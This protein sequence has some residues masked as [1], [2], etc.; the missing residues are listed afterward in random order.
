MV[1]IA[2]LYYDGGLNQQQIAKRLG[3]TRQRVSRLLVSAREE[4][5]V[6]IN[7]F[8]PT[9]ADP[10]LKEQLQETFGLHDVVLAPS[11]GLE[12]SELRSQLGLV[13]AEYLATVLTAGEKVGIG[14]G[15]T[16][17]ETIQ[18]IPRTQQV[19][20]HIVPII[21][22]IGDMSPYFQ[23]NELARKLAEAFNG[24]FRHIY[25]PA[26]TRDK[27]ILK[28]LSKTQEVEQLQELWKALDVAIIG[29]GHV[30]FQQTSAMYF[31]DHISPKVLAQLEAAGAVG[32]VCGRFFNIT[33]KVVS[34]GNGVMGISLEQL[35][36][37]PEVI[38]IA[39]GVEKTSAM[40]GAL[41][42]GF[43]KTL[44]TDTVTARAML[45]EFRERR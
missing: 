34:G 35:Q 38:A 40:L 1:Q 22:G 31:R 42:G 33:G 39:G 9:P 27:A 12:A 41:R 37:V 20:V 7:I 11:E 17:Y 14:W 24:T 21:G 10:H 43:I 29:V 26:F 3:M 6:K 30:E 25:A 18:S 19:P 23:V 45:M 13:A 32:D 2:R 5:I 15:R 8:D 44:I 16:L 28:S 4:G 36:A